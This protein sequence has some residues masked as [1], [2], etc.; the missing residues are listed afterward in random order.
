[1]RV[2]GPHDNDG[3]GRR[4]PMPPEVASRAV[5]D[6]SIGCATLL[7]G[8]GVFVWLLSRSGCFG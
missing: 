7:V 1:M 8:V 6:L 3:P 2:L 4:P 5:R